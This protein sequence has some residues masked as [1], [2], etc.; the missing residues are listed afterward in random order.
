MNDDVEL[1]KRFY[2]SFLQEGDLCFDVGANLGNRTEV[3]LALGAKVVA[4][5]PQTECAQNLKALFGGNPRFTLIEKALGSKEGHAELYKCDDFH[6]ISS[7]STHWIEKVKSSGRFTSFDWGH[8]NVVPMTTLDH[9]ITIFGLPRFC[10]ID[11]E[12]Y[13]FEVLQGL[14]LPI[15]TLSFE[16]IGED[17][18]PTV[19]CMN[20]LTRLGPYKFNV[21]I[22][23]S[24][25]LELDQWLKPA[26]F[27]P[28]LKQQ[29]GLAWGDVYATIDP[30]AENCSNA[31][32]ARLIQNLIRKEGYEFVAE[33]FRELLGREPDPSGLHYF[34]GQLHSGVP[35][36]QIITGIM[37]SEEANL[38]Y[39]HG[40]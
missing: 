4:V 25:F 22:G 7:M 35:K 36:M 31:N 38:R 29:T 14:S 33:A 21:S 30:A 24:M 12:G 3:F 10:K 18:D 37:Q 16:F 13:E 40:L 2:S 27:I 15:P 23:E 8:K 39:H 11:V 28:Y 17:L 1:R 5:E 9:L 19:N 26:Q 6:Q 32:I 34:A 20:Q